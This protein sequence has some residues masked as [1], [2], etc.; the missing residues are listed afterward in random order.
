MLPQNSSHDSEQNVV[1]YTQA[2]TS[3]MYHIMEY[4]GTVSAG[5][6]LKTWKHLLE[7]V[8]SWR[9]KVRWYESDQ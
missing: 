2:D 5:F 8:K 4:E 6:G 7:T 3:Y 1:V 9:I